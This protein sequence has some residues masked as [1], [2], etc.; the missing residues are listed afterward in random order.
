MLNEAFT[1]AEVQQALR[2]LNNCKAVGLSGEPAELLRCATLKSPDG[3]VENAQLP[4]L[5]TIFNAAF[6]WGEIPDQWHT[7]IMTPIH[8]NGGATD[9]CVSQADAR[10]RS[11]SARM[12]APAPA[13]CLA[14]ARGAPATRLSRSQH[15]S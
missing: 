8:K 13:R 11:I 9:T 7:S 14:T 15:P 3:K 10:C 12:R 2:K 4:A 6:L 1:P 5:K